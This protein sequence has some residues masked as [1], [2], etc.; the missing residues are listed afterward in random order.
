MLLTLRGKENPIVVEYKFNMPRFIFK[1]DVEFSK[2]VALKVSPTD[3]VV[4]LNVGTKK[5]VSEFKLFCA[6]MKLIFAL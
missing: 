2:P 4:R 6:C 3:C 1:K 5:D